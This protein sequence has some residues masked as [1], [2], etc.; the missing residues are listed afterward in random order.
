VSDLYALVYVS[1]AT[2]RADVAQ[3]DSLLDR[4]QANNARAG[5]TGV[6]LFDGGCFMQ[7]VEGSAESM[8]RVYTRIKASTLHTGIVEL[9]REPIVRREF[10]EWSMAFRS[11]NA[12]GMSHPAPQSDLLAPP[13][14]AAADSPSI[15]RTI[16][17]RFWNRGR[18]AHAF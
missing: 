4:A 11:V 16:L 3:I 12:F 15:A 1:T 9:M 17:A 14:D 10:P 5:L 7:Y 8:G 6:L 18:S 2:E 13:G